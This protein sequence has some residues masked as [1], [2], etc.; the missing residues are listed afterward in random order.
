MNVIHFNTQQKIVVISAIAALVFAVGF[1][2][3]LYFWVLLPLPN[4]ETLEERLI[5]TLRCQIF[6]ALML[7]AGIATVGNYRF[8][9]P[10]IN[11]LAGAESEAMKVH[12]RY[13]SN[14][15]EQVVLFMIVNVIFSTFLNAQTIKIIP[16]LAILFV[17]ARL[18]FW[19]G[20]LQSP[21]YRAFGMALTLYPT[22]ILLFYDIYHV[23]IN[24]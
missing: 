20:Y 21:M 17:V 15:L 5:F 8:L 6:P 14:T 7:F 10:A 1:V 11:P 4:L 9:S 3:I 12:L 18:A 23:L 2:G 24:F 19:F 22:A 16:I 13:L